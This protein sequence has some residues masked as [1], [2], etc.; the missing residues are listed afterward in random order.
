MPH[1]ASTLFAAGRS[2][3]PFIV[4]PF[5]VHHP[6]SKTPPLFINTSFIVVIL[7]IAFHS[8]FGSNLMSAVRA[9]AM[10]FWK[11]PDNEVYLNSMRTG[12]K[13]KAAAVSAARR[14]GAECKAPPPKKIRCHM[15]EHQGTQWEMGDPEHPELRLP[16]EEDKQDKK[17]ES[18]DGNTK[19]GN[20][21]HDKKKVYDAYGNEVTDEFILYAWEVAAAR[22]AAKEHAA[23]KAGARAK[24]R[25]R[26]FACHFAQQR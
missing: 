16:E 5:I 22:Q 8:R 6:S 15:E 25:A 3:M 11:V 7:T 17:A 23:Q 20:I 26:S 1:P 13:C 14:L 4:Q 21:R 12:A 10:S 19:D 2:T 9:S 24:H 18:T